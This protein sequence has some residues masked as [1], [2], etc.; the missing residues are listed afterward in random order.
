MSVLIVFNHPAP[1]KVNVFNLLAEH[2]DIHVIFERERASDRDEKFYA[3]NEYNFSHEFLSKGAFYKENSN[4]NEIIN[5]LK[6]HKY[7]L[8]IMNGYSKLTEMRTI[9]YLNKKKIK[10]ILF[11]NGGKVKKEG[12]I[13]KAIKKK[14][15]SKASYY[16]SPS[17]D[18]NDYLTYYGADPL[19]IF[20]YPNSTIFEKDLIK[21]P[22][23]KEEKALR[24]KELGLPDNDIIISPCQ[25]IPR[26]NNMEL[27]KI[28][29][30]RK[31]TLLLI[32]SGVE[33]E[34]YLE[35]QKAHKMDNLI[36]MDFMSK[37]KLNEYYK[38][39]KAFITLSKYDIYGHTTN[40]A[41]AQGI[42]VISSNLV[43]SSLHLI[44]NGYN[45]FIIDINNIK[46]INEALD[47]IDESMNINAL[48]TAKENT[49]EKQAEALS[50]I[51]EKIKKL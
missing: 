10:W 19:K 42:P 39:S 8:V 49:M 30:D 27:L 9:N 37:D 33:K 48:N 36:I 5:H 20:N 28:F 43:I 18:A 51:I 4:S 1:Y 11:I 17:K 50:K 46:E 21:T 14:Y 44:K 7:D 23:S 38:I 3:S 6:N 12:L 25:F 34:K 40:E 16:I 31:E 35:Y 29:K 32:G 24:K 2:N 41:L 47:N 45:G 13:K 22:L 15:I 26:K